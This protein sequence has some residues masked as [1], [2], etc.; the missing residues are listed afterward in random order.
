MIW[1][2][3][4]KQ[5]RSLLYSPNVL[6]GKFSEIRYPRLQYVQVAVRHACYS[7]GLAKAAGGRPLPW[8]VGR[9]DDGED[10]PDGAR[11]RGGCRDYRRNRDRKSTR[12]NSSH[13]NISYAV[14]C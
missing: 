13:A 12:L 14:F 10:A 8:R 3:G 6:E 1:G 2:R 7:G 5:P 9:E 4:S 11:V